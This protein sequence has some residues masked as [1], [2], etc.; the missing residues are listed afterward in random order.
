MGDKP[1]KKI[2]ELRSDP[3]TASLELIFENN[4]ELLVKLNSEAAKNF[5]TPAQQVVYYTWKCIDF[6]K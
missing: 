5:R 2:R 3:R 1:I 6:M 4:K